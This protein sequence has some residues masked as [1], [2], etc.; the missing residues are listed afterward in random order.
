MAEVD[1]EACEV[2]SDADPVHAPVLPYEPTER[3]TNI[4]QTPLNR[5]KHCLRQRAY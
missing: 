1:Q 5:T 4:L 3:N 2:A